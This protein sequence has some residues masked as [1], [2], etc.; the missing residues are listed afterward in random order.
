VACPQFIAIQAIGF[1][2]DPPRFSG[3]VFFSEA[4]NDP[5]THQLDNPVPNPLRYVLVELLAASANPGTPSDL[6][7]VPGHTLMLENDLVKIYRVSLHP[8][9]STG[10][11]SRT[12]SWIRISGSQGTVSVQE[13]GK[14][15][16]II[17]TKSG[18]YRW[19]EGPTAQ[20]LK[21]IGSTNYEALEIELK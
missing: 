16:Q 2:S 3:N 1:Y 7:H 10:V 13:L 15:P 12:L 21:N 14:D 8:K 6:D 4:T 17:E 5:Y 11:R 9:Q 18:D 19:H 20:S